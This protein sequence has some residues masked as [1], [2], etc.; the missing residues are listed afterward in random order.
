MVLDRMGI[1]GHQQGQ[2]AAVDSADS[3]EIDKHL[4]I[5]LLEHSL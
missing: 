1:T 5:F 3:T 2:A 4:G